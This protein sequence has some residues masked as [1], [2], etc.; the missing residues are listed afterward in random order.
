MKPKQGRNS[1]EPQTFLSAKADRQ[2]LKGD[3]E[4]VQKIRDFDWSKTPIGPIETW[5]PALRMVVKLMMANRFPMILWWGPQFHQFYNDPYIPIPGT[6]H[7]QALGQAASL[8][9][10][11]IWD[12]IGPLIMTPFRGGEAT[13]AEDILLE[14]NRHGFVEETHFIIAYSPVPDET[15]PGEIGGVLATVHDISGKIV[16]DRRVSVLRDLG[17]R[18]TEGET[19]EEACAIAAQTL[20]QHA[21]DLPFALLYLIDSNRLRAHLAGTS[22]VAAGTPVSP[23]VVDLTENELDDSSWPLK[24][25]LKSESALTIKKPERSFWV[26]SATWSMERSAAHSSGGAN[27]V[28]PGSLSGRIPGC[29]NELSIAA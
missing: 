15:V 8:C 4:M 19:G 24:E 13:W 29:R 1:D 3:G 20:G 14:I 10:M 16:G 9:W 7:P 27:Q 11:E 21:N 17:A 12:V 23:A 6:K 18:S 26:S 22:G 5:S 28:Y 25:V 2:W